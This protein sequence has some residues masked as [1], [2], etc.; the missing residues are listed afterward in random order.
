MIPALTIPRQHWQ[1][2]RRHV[3]H[4]APLE[5]CGLLAGRGDRAE[6]MLK[7]CNTLESPVRFRLDPRE[8]LRAFRWLESRGLELVGIYHS[9]PCGPPHPSPTDVEEAAYPVVHIIW[10]PQDW[11]WRARGYWIE[12]GRVSEVPL[13]LA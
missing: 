7:M 2:M 3:I 4:C 8:Q 6:K 10:S 9:H 13:Q 11:E 12:A 1:A 5:A